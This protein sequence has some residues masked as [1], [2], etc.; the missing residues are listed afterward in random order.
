MATILVATTGSVAAPGPTAVPGAAAVTPGLVV[1]GGRAVVVVAIDGVRWQDVFL[2]VDRALAERHHLPESERVDA[3]HL[4]PH[5]HELMTREGAAVGAPGPGAPMEASG[6]EFVSLPG[7]MEMLTGRTDSGCTSN[8]CGPV[9]YSTVADEVVQAGV[10]RAAVVSSWETVGRAAGAGRSAVA[11]SVGRFAGPGRAVFEADPD[12]APLLVAGAAASPDPGG[13]DYRPDRH[14]A[15]LAAAL[16]SSYKPG[17]VFVGLGDTDEYAH[18]DDYRGYLRAL[19]EA[20]SIVGVI[21]ESVRRWNR[22]GHPSTLLVT[23]DH[24]RAAGFSEHGGQYPESSRVWLVAAGA[25]IGAR[26]LVTSERSRRLADVGQTVRAVMGLPL[27]RA[28]QSGQVL[29]ELF[30][31]PSA[32]TSSL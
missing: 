19:R 2:G 23:T 12:L 8:D 27:A 5:L 15:P 22:E 16:L 30:P 21:A 10:G 13:A 3:A 9:P 4:V 6:P 24:G 11:M 7:Y 28:P 29:T 31:P 17:F 26:G 18:R 14:T 1:D 32:M 20:D 25:G